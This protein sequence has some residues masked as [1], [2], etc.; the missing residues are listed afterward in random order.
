MKQSGESERF[1]EPGLRP[2]SDHQPTLPRRVY[3]GVACLVGGFVAVALGGLGPVS[4]W[5]V[6][7]GF[8]LV[9]AGLFLLRSF[10]FHGQHRSEDDDIRKLYGRNK[11]YPGDA[12]EPQPPCRPRF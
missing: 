8:V 5:L 6:V 1:V 11:P 10:R 9:V 12:A 2:S 4:W 3:T 7:V